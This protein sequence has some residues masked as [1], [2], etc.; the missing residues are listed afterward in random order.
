[1]RA[2]TAGAA[3]MTEAEQRRQFWEW[4]L[5]EAVP[6]AWEATMSS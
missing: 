6:Q 5:T 2:W 1:M 3:G 4:W